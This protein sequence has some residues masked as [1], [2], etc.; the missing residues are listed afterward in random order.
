MGY[1]MLNPVVSTKTVRRN[2]LDTKRGRKYIECLELVDNLKVFCRGIH[3]KER[4]QFDPSRRVKSHSKYS[5]RKFEED[6]V[7]TMKRYKMERERMR[8]R[9]R[10]KTE[11][12]KS[13]KSMKA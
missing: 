9:Y 11:Q 10:E 12:M 5:I 3:S 7:E 8:K 6:F 2:F 1:L 4:A 13:G